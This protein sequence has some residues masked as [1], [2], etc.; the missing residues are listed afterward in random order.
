MKK[1]LKK[2]IEKIERNFPDFSIEEINSYLSKGERPPIGK[3][4]T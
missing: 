4:E 2:K 3:K 1:N